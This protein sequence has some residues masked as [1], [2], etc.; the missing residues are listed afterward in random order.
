MEYFVLSRARCKKNAKGYKR[1][2]KFNDY[3]LLIV[4]KKM[5]IHFLG[6]NRSIASEFSLISVSFIIIFRNSSFTNI[7]AWSL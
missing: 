5:N 6:T 4:L 7:S 3:L 1:M 2:L